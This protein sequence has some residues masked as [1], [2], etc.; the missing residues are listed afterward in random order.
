MPIA[1]DE[2]SR[3]V[4]LR[5]SDSIEVTDKTFAIVFVISCR[6]DDTM[7]DVAATLTGKKEMEK[8]KRENLAKFFNETDERLPPSEGNIRSNRRA[9]KSPEPIR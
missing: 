5:H 8:K 3:L 2:R 6:D 4:R 9:E 7:F 1:I